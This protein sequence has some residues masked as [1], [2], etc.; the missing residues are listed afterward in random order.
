MWAPTNALGFAV[1]F[2]SSPEIDGMLLP[3][4]QCSRLVRRREG[5]EADGK[6]SEYE[7]IPECRRNPRLTGSIMSID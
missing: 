5:R 7:I 3:L 4:R 1:L 2:H 6:D